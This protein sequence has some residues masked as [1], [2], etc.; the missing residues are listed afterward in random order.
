[1]IEKFIIGTVC[2]FIGAALGGNDYGAAE[3]PQ[4][5]GVRGGNT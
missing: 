4:V 1:M 5:D 3:L 2:L